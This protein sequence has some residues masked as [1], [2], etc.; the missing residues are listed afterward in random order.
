[1]AGSFSYLYGKLNASP[2]FNQNI[3]FEFHANVENKN[4]SVLAHWI[5]SQEIKYLD[6][7]AFY[8]GEMA[9]FFSTIEILNCLD[10]INPLQKLEDLLSELKSTLSHELT[11]LVQT[12]VKYFKNLNEEAGL[13]GANTR[14]TSLHALPPQIKYLIPFKDP[15]HSS[16]YIS[17]DVFSKISP[18][19]KLL[20]PKTN[21]GYVLNEINNTIIEERPE[22]EKTEEEK[23]NERVLMVQHPMRD[24][25]FY[26][27][28]KDSI[29][30]FNNNKKYLPAKSQKN[31]AKLMIGD[32]DIKQFIAQMSSSTSKINNQQLDNMI[33]MINSTTI[34]DHALYFN[35][36]YFNQP[37][38]Y[39]KAIKE[40]YKAIN[41]DGLS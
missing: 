27:R 36:L 24:I 26:T 38:K 19:G 31:F 23:N 30:Y 1:L 2:K 35:M 29:D 11:H 6:N 17:G 20:N 10:L 4:K 13:P 14:E 21:R 32:M 18:T 40:F 39:E 34:K 9:V 16:K 28:L 5:P 25:E 3:I 37:L 22:S 15:K 41:Y 8:A 12:I 7:D 33:N